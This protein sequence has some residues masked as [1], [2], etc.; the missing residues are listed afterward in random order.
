M[1]KANSPCLSV[2]P[3]TILLDSENIALYWPQSERTS[4]RMGA[5]RCVYVDHKLVLCS[6]LPLTYM[7]HF[8]FINFVFV[9]GVRCVCAHRHVLRRNESFY[10]GD[11]VFA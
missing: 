11:R 10:Y 5:S 9:G 8:P 6:Q 2:C 1:R 4:W 7:S 3:P